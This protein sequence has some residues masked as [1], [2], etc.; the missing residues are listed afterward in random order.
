MILSPAANPKFGNFPAH[1]AEVCLPVAQ[2]TLS[3]L[4]G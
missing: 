3:T 4:E 1:H 2:A